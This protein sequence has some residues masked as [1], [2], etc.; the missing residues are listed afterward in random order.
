MKIKFADFRTITR[1]KT[2]GQWLVKASPL[3]DIAVQ[4]LEEA[5][6][7]GEPVRLLGVSVSNLSHEAEDESPQLCLGF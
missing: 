3:A 7:A 6:L 4:L 1:S 2:C 5:P